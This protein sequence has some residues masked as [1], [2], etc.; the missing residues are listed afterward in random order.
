MSQLSKIQKAKQDLMAARAKL[1]DLS[2]EERDRIGK[3][4]QE[5]DFLEADDI[6][7]VAAVLYFK[8]A[9]SEKRF[10]IL[11]LIKSEAPARFRK[12]ISTQITQFKQTKSKSSSS[13]N[14]V[15][16]AE[17]NGSSAE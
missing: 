9:P 3:L 16:E 8:N 5:L 15:G 11:E 4:F 2:R 12:K 1:E 13:E 14:Q 7:I 6:E 10:E 17:N